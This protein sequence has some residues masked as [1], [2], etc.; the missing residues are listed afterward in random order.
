MPHQAPSIAIFRCFRR[1][2]SS[3]RT[4]QVLL[5]CS[6]FE[7]VAV[8]ESKRRAMAEEKLNSYA[9][10]CAYL[11]KTLG[12]AMGSASRDEVLADVQRIR[13]AEDLASQQLLRA[14]PGSS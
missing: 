4:S 13:E 7:T 9:E 2:L 10:E 1:H 3:P 5:D 14:P 8:H 11:R 6:Q 12:N